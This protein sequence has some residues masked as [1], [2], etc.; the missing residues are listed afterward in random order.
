[1]RA[2]QRTDARQ[3]GH[4][5]G[6]PRLGGIKPAAEGIDA[7][8][9]RSLDGDGHELV[10]PAAVISVRSADQGSSTPMIGCPCPVDKP[11][12]GGDVVLHRAVAVEMVGRDVEQDGDVGIKLTAQVELVG[13]AFE[14]IDRAAVRPPSEDAVPILPP[15]ARRGPPL[16][17]MW[18]IRA[19]VVD[20]PLVPVMATM[21]APG[22]CSAALRARRARCRR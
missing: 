18:P 20:L 22:A 2:G 19:V 21:G 8:A 7:A 9:Q 11:R 10:A 14:H 12:L 3:V 6:P 15:S 16:R 4:F 17:D 1:M 13:R 5:D